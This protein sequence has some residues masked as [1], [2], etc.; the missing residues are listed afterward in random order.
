M[1]SLL[2]V[3]LVLGMCFYV[4]GVTFTVATTM[5]LNSKEKY[6]DPS[7][8]GVRDF[9]GTLDRS[10]LSLFM[11]MSGGNDWAVFYEALEHLPIQYRIIF[12]LYISFALFA[13]V[14]IVTGIFV[15]TAMQSNAQDRDVTVH[16]EMEN[17]KNYLRSMRD[18]FEAMDEDDTGSV[19]L[20]EFESKLADE[21]VIA[22]FNA[23]KLDVSDARRL[24]FLLDYDNSN[25]VDI[26]EFLTGCYSLQGES[27]ALDMKLMQHEVAF[28]R[29]NFAEIA[30]TVE[31]VLRCVSTLQT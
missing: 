10:F 8:Q 5:A 2:W 14:N 28:L 3:M 16:E 11:A 17:K 1:K 30:E 12:L 23:L 27:R 24:F 7:T 19:S 15:E 18:I 26:D 21:R 4:F 25:E 31:K 6:Q 29:D 22:Y 20:E 13:V 9:F